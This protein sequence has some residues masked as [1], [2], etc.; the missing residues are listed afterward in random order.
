MD[1]FSF[2]APFLGSQTVT[3]GNLIL[4]PRLHFFSVR[5]NIF[6]LEWGR[7]LNSGDASVLEANNERIHR[8]N[9]QHQYKCMKIAYYALKLMSKVQRVDLKIMPI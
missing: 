2:L 6:F 8:I 4:L 3:V 1:T 5:G 9:F 7:W